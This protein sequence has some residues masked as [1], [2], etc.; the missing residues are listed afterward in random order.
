MNNLRGILS[1]FYRLCVVLRQISLNFQVE[2]KKSYKQRRN[3]SPLYI[4]SDR[5]R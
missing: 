1:F 4:V 5:Y 3:R 2:K